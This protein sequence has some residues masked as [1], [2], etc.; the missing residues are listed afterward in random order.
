MKILLVSSGNFFSSYGGG[1]VYV[2]NITEEMIRQNEKITIIS[3]HASHDKGI[4]S[5]IYQGILIYEINPGEEE[6]NIKTLV[7]KINPDII[8]IHGE[9]A[10]FCKL[11]REMGIPNV[12]T[13][14]HGG[15]VCPAGTLLNEKDEICRT[16]VCHNNCLPCC[17][18]N[19]RSGKYWYPLMKLLPTKSYLTIGEILT[20]LPFILFI[21][22]IGQTALSIPKKQEEWNTVCKY[23]DNVIAPS[24]AIAEAM[25]RN[26]MPSEKIT[27]VP[28][29]IPL[30]NRVL[31]QPSQSKGI[32]FFYAG[33]I[34]DV[35]GIHILLAAFHQLTSPNAELHLIGD[36]NNRYARH[37]QQKYKQDNRIIWHGYI[38]NKQIYHIINSFHILIHPAIYLEVFGLNIAEALAMGKPVLAT[39]CGGAEMQI[40][41]GKNGWLVEPNNPE[42]L[43]N[44][45]EKIMKGTLPDVKGE[46]VISI[47][48]HCKVLI[49][50]YNSFSLQNTFA[51]GE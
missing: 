28:H 5:L 9:K 33:R 38:P 27:V 10:L 48:D 44:T 21:T 11:S 37:L 42:A 13:A 47:R 39:R 26:G 1:Q 14:H 35:K 3:C 4:K 20:K 50:I 24:H 43:K 30:P 36:A 16:T 31:P 25:A 40:E 15:I 19:I 7:G 17:L 46:N 22:P 6:K 41:E 32:R 45:M 34:C 51:N 12:V 23:S 49:Q 8:H 2:K 29:G 18:R